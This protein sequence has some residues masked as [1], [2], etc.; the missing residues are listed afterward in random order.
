VATLGVHGKMALAWFWPILSG[1]AAQ[2]SCSL[3]NLT[4]GNVSCLTAELHGQRM[5]LRHDLLTIAV[6][7]G[8]GGLDGILLFIYLTFVVQILRPTLFKASGWLA[9]TALGLLLMFI[10][11]VARICLFFA[12]AVIGKYLFESN[13]SVDLMLILFHTHAGWL[14]FGTGIFF[15]YRTAAG[16][17]N[18]YLKL[19]RAVA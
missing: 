1:A 14:L 8:C 18:P 9:F 7:Q 16:G 15:Y 3:L 12:V 19:G 5:I 17:L 4:L 6:G 13:E 11:N 10:I 2:M